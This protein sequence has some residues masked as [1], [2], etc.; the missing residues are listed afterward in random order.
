MGKNRAVFFN[1]GQ[2]NISYTYF[3]NMESTSFYLALAYE[4]FLMTLS[5]PELSKK[6]QPYP[7]SRI[8]GG[9]LMNNPYVHTLLLK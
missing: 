8:F 4:F 7:L 5:L 6:K 1:I 9:K 3:V 2:Y